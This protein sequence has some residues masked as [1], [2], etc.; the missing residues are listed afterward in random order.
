VFAF[1]CVLCV[2]ASCQVACTEGWAQCACGAA[3]GGP[4]HAGC[5]TRRVLPPAVG[6]SCTAGLVC[7]VLPQ[8]CVTSFSQRCACAHA[9][10]SE[11]CASVAWFGQA[12]SLH[13]FTLQLC[14]AVIFE[15]TDPVT[16][17]HALTHFA[18]PA[19]LLHATVHAMPY[20]TG[21]AQHITGRKP[22]NPGLQ[23]QQQ[24][25]K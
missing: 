13:F 17:C 8:Q 1:E 15:S 7:S 14:V 6:V 10:G 18:P 21:H 20:C 11:G 22:T 3:E 5:D 23:H 24:L 16:Q 19:R 9:V 12:A 2:C 4:M 25:A